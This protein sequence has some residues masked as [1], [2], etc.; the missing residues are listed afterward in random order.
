MSRKAAG[1]HQANSMRLRCGRPSCS[2]GGASGSAKSRST[3]GASRTRDTT[4]T[5]TAYASKPSHAPSPHTRQAP[6]SSNNEA[7]A[8]ITAAVGHR[9]ATSSWSGGVF[10]TPVNTQ[11]VQTRSS[12]R[13]SGPLPRFFLSAQPHLFWP[14]C[15]EAAGWTCVWQEGQ[16]GTCRVGQVRSKI[17]F[18][19]VT[20]VA[21]TTGRL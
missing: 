5:L 2:R 14:F 6:M 16:G 15:C 10:I 8:R 11:G 12:P 20:R 7:P 1:T 18:R 9:S 17:K 13:A 21:E 3:M 19:H 4:P